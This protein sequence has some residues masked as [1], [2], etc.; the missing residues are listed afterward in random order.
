MWKELVSNEIW[1]K[2][3]F[4]PED[5]LASVWQNCIN[6]ENFRMCPDQN[7]RN[8]FDGIDINPTR[9]DYTVHY[10]GLR[11]NLALVEFYRDELNKFFNEVNERPFPPPPLWPLQLFAK[12]F[13][14]ESY[15]ELH[16][17]PMSKFGS[18]AFVHFLESCDGAELVFPSRQTAK[19]VLDFSPEQSEAL[20]RTGDVFARL[21]EKLRWVGHLEVSPVKNHCVIFRT[22][23][24]HFVR[25]PKGA[26]R[27]INRL[28]VT[29]WPFVSDQLI[30]DLDR[31]CDLKKNFA[32]G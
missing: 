30:E 24:L 21:C 9:Y 18:F 5:S 8:V 1:L 13:S 29:G 22:G 28:A 11:D 31:T 3:D 32:N 2:T 25:P 20:R 27:E 19:E 14:P 16:A 10:G 23:S 15:Y 6:S 26:M 17:E 7:I 4:M 12:S